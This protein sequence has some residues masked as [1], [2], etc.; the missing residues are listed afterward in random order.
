MDKRFNS[1]YRDDLH[2]FVGAMVDFL[3]ESARRTRRTTIETFLNPQYQRKYDQDIATMRDVAEECILQRRKNP[4]A[5]RDL[6]HALLFGKDPKTG[7]RMTDQS[8]MDNMITFLIAGHETT[9]GMLSYA[10]YYLLKNSECL[11]KAQAEVDQV[12][13]RGPITYQHMSKLPY[14]EAILRETLRLSPTATALAVEPLPN[15]A[16]PIILGG[17]YQIPQGQTVVVFLPSLGRDP[18]AFGADADVWR[19]ERMYGDNFAKNQ[20][21]WKPFG[22]GVR[23]CIGRP[24]AWQEAILAVA[25]MLQNFNLR[26]D[27]P[28][29]SL[30]HKQTL[31]VKPDN[32]YMKAS[33]REGIDPIGLEKAL[34]SGAP[35]TSAKEK[36]PASKQP[37]T[38]GKPL[39]IYYGSNSGTCEGLSQTLAGAASR[40]GYY[41][42]VQPLDS[43]I[44]KLG[45]DEPSV[46]ITASYE[47]EP[48]DNAAQFMQWL[49]T[50]EASKVKDCHFAVFAVGHHDWVSTFHKVPKLVETILTE[51]GARSIVKL[52]ETDVAQGTIF[53]DFDD[54]VDNS[55]FPALTGKSAD[56]SGPEGL[57]MEVTTSARATHLNHHVQDAVVLKNERLTPPN[58]DEKRHME[59]KL[60]TGMTYREYP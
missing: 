59:F 26:F 38:S 40:F 23:G 24:F 28:S 18:E 7:E 20:K 25:I 2:P 17:C 16:D 46:I 21:A 52:G 4:S 30:Q 36:P 10:T 19:P 55:F 43:A 32:F 60:P 58:M 41:A 49:K 42:K 6:L 5:K 13:G 56:S 22:N 39:S 54:W 44:D 47:G 29:Y 45:A 37:I 1:F 48:P 57:D 53:D 15:S 51:K 33:L 9:S 11:Q 27:D 12:C 31:T 50:V 3:V 34:F 35:V 8:I 14:I